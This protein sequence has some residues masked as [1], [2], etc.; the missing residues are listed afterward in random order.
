MRRWRQAE[1]KF[2]TRGGARRGAGRKAAGPRPRVPHRAR[3]LHKT[4]HPVHVTLR[5]SRR[6]PSLRAQRVFDVIRRGF[7]RTSRSWFRI[8]HFSVQSDHV[9]LLVEA[10]DKR[11]LSRGLG[12]AAIRMAL[13]IN[14]ALR[15]RGKVWA[16]RGRSLP[17]AGA[18][19]AAG[20][21]NRP[22]LCAHELEEARPE[23]EAPRSMCVG[24]ALHGMEGAACRR[25]AR[26]VRA[27]DTRHLA[28]ANRLEAP[29]SD[30]A[31]RTTEGLALEQPLTSGCRSGA[32][33]HRARIEWPAS[34]RPD[35]P[36]MA[37]CQACSRALQPTACAL[38]A[39]GCRRDAL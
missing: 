3:P 30:W 31:T 29:R 23:R 5:A 35:T 1:L 10:D 4:A 38:N 17:R 9:H 18:A 26:G 2:R 7:A 22:R 21:P 8:V 24:V 19:H 13:A 27:R 15:R 33:R 6:L 28:L 11:S 39:C 12:G 20:S 25:A 34:T 16:D 14:R 36:T 37:R 32:R